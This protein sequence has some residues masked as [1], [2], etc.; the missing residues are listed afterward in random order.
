MTDTRIPIKRGACRIRGLW[1]KM[2]FSNLPDDE[3]HLVT[4]VVLQA[5]SPRSPIQGSW[6]REGVEVVLDSSSLC[7]QATL[8]TPES[9][10]KSQASIGTI[11]IPQDSPGHTARVA[12]GSQCP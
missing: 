10:S 3:N 12:L 4:N 11:W 6:G 5:P 9:G 8:G 1:E 2:Q 7:L